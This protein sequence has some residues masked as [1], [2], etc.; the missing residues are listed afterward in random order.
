MK[1]S[2]KTENR[3]IFAKCC[4]TPLAI[5]ADHSHLNLVYSNLIKPINDWNCK[6]NEVPYPTSVC[7]QYAVCLHAEN[8]G[9]I[10]D[11]YKKK[12]PTMKIIPTLV[13]P[14]TILGI[15]GRLVLLMGMGSRG[16]GQGLYLE[17]EI[18][19]GYESI[20]KLMKK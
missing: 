8:L 16:P 3:R 4:G 12:Y 9:N 15:L 18:G 11:E 10:P 5:S 19:I 7:A 14:V 2:K 20:P 6:E 1:L 13:A 17:K